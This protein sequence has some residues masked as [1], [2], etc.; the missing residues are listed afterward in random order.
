MMSGFGSVCF[1]IL[2][3]SNPILSIVPIG[4]SIL[5][6]TRTGLLVVAMMSV[7]LSFS[8]IGR[9][10]IGFIL[11][12]SAVVVFLLG[13][14]MLNDG[15]AARSSVMKKLGDVNVC[16]FG[17]GARS[18]W[19]I[20]AYDIVRKWPVEKRLIGDGFDTIVFHLR[21]P[22]GVMRPDGA[23]DR[24]HNVAMDIILQTGVLGYTLSLLCLASCIHCVLDRA[25]DRNKMCL[26]GILAWIVFGMFN[27]QGAAADA[28]MVCCVFGMREKH[29]C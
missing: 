25:D 6:G 14:M 19:I 9:K 28:M 18:S 17:S 13:M 20:Q 16:S 8:T 29:D 1:A 21:N 3:V 27:P 11:S 23:P 7:Y 4:C 12:A 15:S 22:G 24:T 26:A 10:Y 2:A 5:V